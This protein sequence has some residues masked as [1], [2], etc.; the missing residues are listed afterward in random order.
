[1]APK[2]I[3]SALLEHNDKFKADY[4]FATGLERSLRSAPADV[5]LPAVDA[6]DFK[7]QDLILVSRFTKTAPVSISSDKQPSNY[8]PSISWFSRLQNR[9]L[10]DLLTFNQSESHAAQGQWRRD[11]AAEQSNRLK[12]MFDTDIAEIYRLIGKVLME[13][14]RQLELSR[15]IAENSDERSNPSLS[16]LSKTNKVI[17]R[18]GARPVTHHIQTRGDVGIY[19]RNVK[20][21][22]SVR[23]ISEELNRRIK[24]IKS[25]PLEWQTLHEKIGNFVFTFENSI[26]LYRKD[27]KNARLIRSA[28]AQESN[29]FVD[30]TRNLKEWVI[31]WESVEFYRKRNMK[32]I[33]V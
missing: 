24:L 29:A 23:E 22:K 15:K 4:S 8:F 3:P 12:N 11:S 10:A 31:C 14:F 5:S 25:D 1:M 33:V 2:L 6:D 21:R 20:G 32:S 19:T 17:S 7:S 9:R 16:N 30:R 27:K 26:E 13:L 28:P 18:T